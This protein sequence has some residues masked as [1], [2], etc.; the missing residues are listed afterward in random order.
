VYA[1]DKLKEIQNNLEKWEEITLQKNMARMPERKDDFMTTSSEPIKRLFTPLDVSG[2]DYL[3]DLG[4]P[5]QYPYT[6]GASNTCSHKGKQVSR[7]LLTY[8]P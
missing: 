4:M 1:R 5:G 6:R 2:M 8:P 3:E 7:L